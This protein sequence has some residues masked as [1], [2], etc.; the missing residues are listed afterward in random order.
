MKN[1]LL[2]LKFLYVILHLCLIQ[3][4]ETY[5][6]ATL[7]PPLL[8]CSWSE[9]KLTCCVIFRRL[10]ESTLRCTVV[11]CNTGIIQPPKFEPIAD[12]KEG[13]K[14]LLVQSRL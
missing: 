4:V 8:C 2:A 12:S 5:Q 10:S 13:E 14:E 1:P 6:R 9:P 7:A 3:A 11:S